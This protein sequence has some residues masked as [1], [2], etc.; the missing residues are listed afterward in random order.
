[1]ALFKKVWVT[2]ALDVLRIR[3]ADDR[4]DGVEPYVVPVF[5][6]VDGERYLA[7]LR[8]NHAQQP[9]EGSTEQEGGIIQLSVDTFATG[10]SPDEAKTEDIQEDNPLVYVPPGD[11]LGRGT[12][13][14]GEQLL[15]SD[16][17]FKTRLLPIP[18]RI[19]VSGTYVSAVEAFGGLIVG[20]EGQVYA[21]LNTVFV[22]LDDFIGDLFGLDEVFE[23]CP[24]TDEGSSEF[25]EE[26]DAHFKAMIPGTIGGLFVCMENDA[27]DESLA[28][29]L[30]SSVRD[31]VASVINDTVNALNLINA[32]PDAE[33][34]TDTVEIQDNILWDLLRPVATDVTMSLGGLSL[35]GIVASALTGGGLTGLYSI[36]TGLSWAAGGKDDTIGQLT[37]TYDHSDLGAPGS[38]P[39]RSDILESDE[40]D[41]HNVWELGHTLKVHGP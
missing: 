35:G 40:N 23:T 16:V 9:R 6:K 31:E 39:L 24:A 26:M 8:I 30:R 27:F 25:L 41:D 5:F 11:L 2:L 17:F 28:K 20:L 38:L 3:A 21:A 29:D 19:D 1:V 13:D 36:L 37:L 32:I 10:V 12:F 34:F 4:Y 14:S 22:S 15:M 7:S 33:R 18:F